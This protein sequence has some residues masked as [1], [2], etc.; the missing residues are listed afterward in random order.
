MH[1]ETVDSQE[2]QA[3]TENVEIVLVVSLTLIQETNFELLFPL[4]RWAI[5]SLLHHLVELVVGFTF[6]VVV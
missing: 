6:F 2:T 5:V 1:F 3:V 4:V